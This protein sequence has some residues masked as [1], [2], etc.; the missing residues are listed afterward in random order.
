MDYSHWKNVAVATNRGQKS[1]SLPYLQPEGIQ[2]DV[3]VFIFLACIFQLV[4]S[5][6]LL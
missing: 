2:S 3:Q 5:F 6:E 1:H 4:D